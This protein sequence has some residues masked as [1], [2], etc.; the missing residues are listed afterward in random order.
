MITY[1]TNPTNRHVSRIL[2]HKLDMGS[3]ALNTGPSYRNNWMI[4]LKCI[5]G[6]SSTS[7]SY[8][9][10]KSPSA[11][12]YIYEEKKYI[13]RTSHWLFPIWLYDTISN[14]LI[15]I[16]PLWIISHII[17]GTISWYVKKLKDI[18]PTSYLIHTCIIRHCIQYQ[19]S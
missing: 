7:S 3:S 11:T 15:I 6:L 12:C 16:S 2:N 13:V 9:T 5:S 4:G 10:T 14:F 17:S 18:F 1:P 8:T 19:H